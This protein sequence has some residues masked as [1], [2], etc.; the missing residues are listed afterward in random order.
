M[1]AKAKLSEVAER[2][3]CPEGRGGR[4]RPVEVRIQRQ[5]ERCQETGPQRG[6]PH[7]AAEEAAP[8]L[9]GSI[10][11][12]RL[13]LLQKPL[14]GPPSRPFSSKTLASL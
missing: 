13:G 1:E 10:G 9:S 11:T 8:W 7:W 12:G 5:A 6:W 4:E 3:R 14:L 2:K